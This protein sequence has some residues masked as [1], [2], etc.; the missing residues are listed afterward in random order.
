[1]VRKRVVLETV[2][3]DICGKAVQSAT[4]QTFAFGAERWEIDVCAKDL[5]ILK[6][7]FGE[8]TSTARKVTSRRRTARQAHD[9]WSYLEKMGFTRHRGRKSAEETAAL[10]ARK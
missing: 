5:A 2:E 4:T 6:K 10:A 7:Q 9:E 3:C 8:W 1:M